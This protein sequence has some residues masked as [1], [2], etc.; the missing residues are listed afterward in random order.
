[1]SY[2]SAIDA[3]YCG[4]R[5]ANQPQ[6]QPLADTARWMRGWEDVEAGGTQRDSGGS[7]LH[8]MVTRFSHLSESSLCR[9]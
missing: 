2:G 5:L 7:Q 4:I 6:V 9:I 3:L 1:V 8:R